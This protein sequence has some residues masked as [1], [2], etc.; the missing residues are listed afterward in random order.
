MTLSI[1]GI[2]EDYDRMLNQI[3]NLKGDYRLIPSRNYSWEEIVCNWGKSW[4]GADH[5]L[6]WFKQEGLFLT[7]WPS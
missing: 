2:R 3:L 4:Y 6:D 1:V 7:G 5:D